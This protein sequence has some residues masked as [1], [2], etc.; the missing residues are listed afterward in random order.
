MSTA[1]PEKCR[2]I[3]TFLVGQYFNICN[4]DRHVVIWNSNELTLSGDAVISSLSRQETL[5]LPVAFVTYSGLGVI[6]VPFLFAVMEKSTGQNYLG[7]HTLISTESTSRCVFH[8]FISTRQL[9]TGT[10]AENSELD[11]WW[12]LWDDW[13]VVKYMSESQNPNLYLI[14]LDFFNFLPLTSHLEIQTYH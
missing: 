1:K 5:C 10:P 13:H 14:N 7:K 8:C 6:S 11:G 9:E 2:H 12:F 3:W 4:N